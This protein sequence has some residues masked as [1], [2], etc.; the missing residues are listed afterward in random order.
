MVDSEVVNSGDGTENKEEI[1]LDNVELI[2][3][4]QLETLYKMAMKFYKEN[5]KAGKLQ[6]EYPVRLRFMAYSKQARMGTFKDELADVGWFDFIGSDA[7]NEWKKLGDISKEQAMIEFVRL[8]DVVCP[9]FKSFTK[10]QAAIEAPKKHNSNPDK[11]NNYFNDL[12]ESKEVIEK[13]QQQKKQIQEA[14]NQQTHHQFLAYAQQTLPGE[15]LKQ[16]E[17]IKQLQEQHY[18][19]YMSQCYA[20]QS[21]AQAESLEAANG[22]GSDTSDSEAGPKPPSSYLQQ[23]LERPPPKDKVRVVND[24]EDSEASDEEAQEDVPSNPKIA[25]AN[26]WTVKNIVEFKDNI[27]KEGPEGVL[28]CG[29][30]E[31]VTVRVPT[32]NEGTCLF[33]EFA[34]DYYDIGFGVY[35]EWTVAETNQVTVHI[36]ESSDEEYDEEEGATEGNA[37]G[38][39]ES[40]GPGKNLKPRDPNKPQVDEIVSVFRRDS[41]EEVY[42]GSHAY[43]GRGVYLLKF[44]NS[45]SLWR[46]KNVYYRVYYHK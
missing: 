39:V 30:G 12:G 43:P 15:P 46:S 20:R 24:D 5:E 13:Y 37:S 26:L 2:F 36:S 29:H 41:H 33:W 42:C 23:G 7:R 10:E 25:P 3:G 31:T 44:D 21:Q 34:T 4:F 28:K 17:L 6:V 40:G 22:K 16:E 14:L 32:H 19:Q 38:D 9:A 1:T 27:R 45:Y 18:S 8:L 11:L 35:F